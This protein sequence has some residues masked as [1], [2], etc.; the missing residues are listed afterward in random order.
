MLELKFIE[1]DGPCSIPLEPLFDE[2]S[3]PP[4]VYNVVKG[5]EF[6]GEIKVGLTFT[7]EVIPCF[8]LSFTLFACQFL[9]SL[10]QN[11]RTCL[12]PRILWLIA[13][14]SDCI[15]LLPFLDPLFLFTFHMFSSTIFK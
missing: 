3:I 12:A 13:T 2:G 9:E 4:T 10:Q 15:L 5:E 8:A 1:C 6:R 11:S 7:P 14:H